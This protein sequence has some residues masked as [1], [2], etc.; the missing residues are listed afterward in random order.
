MPK[1]PIVSSKNTP[2]ALLAQYDGG[3]VGGYGRRRRYTRAEHVE[4]LA[5]DKYKKNDQGLTLNDLLSRGLASN[6]K[7]GQIT[8]KHYRNQGILFT[9]SADKPQQYYP[10]CIKSE[11]LKAKVVKNIPIGVIEVGYSYKAHKQNGILLKIHKT[12]NSVACRTVAVIDKLT[13]FN[14]SL[15]T[16][17]G[18]MV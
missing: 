9:I 13:I 8:L 2:L 12:N 17:T 5:V 18:T 15:M 11:I 6:K 7:Q 16:M 3:F 14:D 1:L 4:K 10:V